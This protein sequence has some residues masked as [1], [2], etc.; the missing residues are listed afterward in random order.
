MNKLADSELEK[1]ITLLKQGQLIGL[2]TETVY[3]L[4]ADANNITAINKIFAAKTRPQNHPLIV[5]IPDQHYLREWAYDIPELAYTLVEKF[6]PGPLTLLLKKH[7]DI[8]TV[9]TGGKQT[10]GLRSPDHPIAQQVLQAFKSGLAAPSANRFCR[11][12]STTAG[13]VKTELGNK[14][15]YII[16]GG[17]CDV[18]IE[19]TILDL[20]QQTPTIVRPGILDAETLSA[21]IN[22]NIIYAEHDIAQTPGNMQTHYAP[23]TPSHLIE[24]NK[25]SS[26]NNNNIAI[27][28]FEKPDIVCKKW[29]K[30]NNNPQQ[31][32]HDLYHNL[33]TLDEL[34][35]DAI[36]IS[37]PP[38]NESWHAILDRLKRICT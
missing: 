12:S 19:S 10:I 15:A 3:G 4:A 38:S 16:D 36:Y 35:C 33:R 29:L 14:V 37:K 31:Y 28:S 25:T 2:P 13:D 34:N 1:I 27:L 7:T 8:N 22:E 21:A 17:S 6:W 26:L 24:E 18:G 23:L 5:H 32:A 30:A 11:I 9:V 20:T